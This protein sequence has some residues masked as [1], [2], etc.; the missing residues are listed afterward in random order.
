MTTRQEIIDRISDQD[1][2]KVFKEVAGV[3]DINAITK[4]RT[5]TPGVY[6]FR[7][8]RQAGANTAGTGVV[9]KV[10][11]SYAVVI[12]EDTGRDTRGGDASD[13]I[14]A[15][16]EQIQSAL[17]NWIPGSGKRG[18]EYDGGRLVTIKGGRIFWQEIYTLPGNQ[19]RQLN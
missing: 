5:S 17:L 9:Q 12:V 1:T 19:I 7:L 11:D 15:H 16:C 13:L 18:L 3:S 14:E 8:R 10:N 6:V 4:G 2:A